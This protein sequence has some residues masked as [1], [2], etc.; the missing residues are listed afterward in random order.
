MTN[1]EDCIETHN[2][3]E[4]AP[5]CAGCVAENDKNKTIAELTARCRYLY[6]RLLE[7]QDRL[8]AVRERCEANN[9]MGTARLCGQ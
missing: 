5:D 3:M 6:N 8:A 9:W 2:A 4:K 1:C 7:E